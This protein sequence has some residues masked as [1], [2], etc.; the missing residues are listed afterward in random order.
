MQTIAAD[1]RITIFS[2]DIFVVAGMPKELDIH[3]GLIV[4]TAFSA[5]KLFEE[6]IVILTRDEVIAASNQLPVIW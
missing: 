4:A 3:D 1:A 5:Q 2:L 6:E